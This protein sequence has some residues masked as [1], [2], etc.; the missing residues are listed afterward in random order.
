MLNAMMTHPPALPGS[1]SAGDHHGIESPRMS[2][3]KTFGPQR[4]DFLTLHFSRVDRCPP[5]AAGNSG[6]YRWAAAPSPW[7]RPL[8]AI[9]SLR[10]SRGGRALEK[11]DEGQPLPYWSIMPTRRTVCK[12]C[13]IYAGLPA[14]PHI[15]SGCGGDRDR[16]SVPG[17]RNA[18]EY[19][20][21]VILTDNPCLKIARRLS[22]T[23]W[24]GLTGDAERTVTLRIGGKPSATPGSVAPGDVVLIAGKGHGRIR[25]SR[26]SVTI[27]MTEVAREAPRPGRHG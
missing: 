6:I 23:C 3:R 4:G 27:S 18:A 7:R 19:S 2:G 25:K 1:P 11:V 26:V 5:A 9:R 22:P 15:A 20:D 8:E 24:K 16:A 12:M 13:L 21:V 10:R 14:N 17:W